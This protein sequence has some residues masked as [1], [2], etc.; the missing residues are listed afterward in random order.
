MKR[1][2]YLHHVVFSLLCNSWS[3]SDSGLPL[4]AFVMRVI[5]NRG[6]KTI[7]SIG[8]DR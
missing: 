2:A 1:T 7:G 5:F 8:S 6:V 3:H 4:S